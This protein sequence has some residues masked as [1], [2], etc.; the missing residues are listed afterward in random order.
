[1]HSITSK[2]LRAVLLGTALLITTSIT[3]AATLVSHW[4][5]DGTPLDVVGTNEGVINNA[6]NYTGGVIGQ[7]FSF[8]GGYIDVSAPNLNS[9]AAAFSF[10]TWIRFD[11]L[12]APASIFNFRNPA[13]TRGFT[14]E[15]LFAQP[16]SL[17]FYLFKDDGGPV[18]LLSSAGWQTGVTYHL[19]ATF[20]GQTM[21]VYRDGTLV[22]SRTDAPS[23]MAQV[24]S[25]YLQ[26]GR[27]TIY[28]STFDGMMDDVR[29]YSGSLTSGEVSLL[30]NPAPEPSRGLLGA[31]GLLAVLKQRRRKL[32][33][34]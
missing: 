5:G 26:I 12:N 14:L 28:G 7:A 27:N 17:A 3:H 6:V 11:A 21:A 4:T 13:N 8:D 16:G 24:N 19:A 10:A 30:I 18:T 22:A 29:F 25:P 34:A 31:I 15:H 32:A 20:D 2:T 23:P 33:R 1:M 9:Y